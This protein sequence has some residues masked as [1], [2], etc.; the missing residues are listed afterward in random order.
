M[1]ATKNWKAK[2]FL[3]G[4]ITDIFDHIALMKPGTYAKAL[5]HALLA[6]SLISA[7]HQRITHIRAQQRQRGE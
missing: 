7:R 2:K 1:V 4:L 6:E 3:K 5:K